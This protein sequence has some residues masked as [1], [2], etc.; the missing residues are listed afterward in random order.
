MHDANFQ[1]D[2]FFMQLYFLRAFNCNKMSIA[3]QCHTIVILVTD[4]CRVAASL[5]TN[6]FV[7]ATMEKIRDKIKYDGG[8]RRRRCER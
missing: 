2:H 8:E 1:A 3:F 4:M 5:F 7:N 6:A